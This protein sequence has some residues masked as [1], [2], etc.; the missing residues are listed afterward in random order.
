MSP[1]RPEHRAP[2]STLIALA[3]LVAAL[4]PALTLAATSD[5]SKQKLP[6]NIQANNADFTQKSGVSTYT[7]NVHLT[8]GGLTLTGNKL[9]VTQM[10]DKHQ[11]K[12][13]LTGDPAHIDKQPDS[14]DNEVVT[15]HAQQIE[16][17]NASS[18]I[19]LRGDAVINRN[20]DQI[21]G[22]VITHNVDTGATHAERGQGKDERVHITIQ[23]ANQ[24]GS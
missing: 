18:V 2:R 1:T 3:L 5:A 16:Y 17:S 8:R 10:N 15:G 6:I 14:S 21:R 9:V 7:G 13:V 4:T 24:D 19:T 20:G 11:I 23:P 12:A 22:A